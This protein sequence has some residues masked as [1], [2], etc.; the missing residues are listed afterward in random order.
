[1][2]SVWIKRL[3]GLLNYS[4]QIRFSLLLVVLILLS[5]FPGGILQPTEK[6]GE[7]GASFIN[8]KCDQKVFPNGLTLL[9]AS[10]HDHELV[11]VNLYARMGTL[12]EAPDQI[13]ISL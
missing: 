11:S 8:G 6:R 9:I 10:T 1:M 7:T 4:K 13:G 5:I 12:Y 2:R 3:C